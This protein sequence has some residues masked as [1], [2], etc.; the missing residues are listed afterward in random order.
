MFLH[1]VLEEEVYMK[2]APG[3]E[4]VHAPNLVCRLDRAI[5][6]LKQAPRAWYARLS[7]KLVDLGFKASKSDNSLYIVYI[8]E[9]I[10]YDVHAYLCG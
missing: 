4:N 5:Y 3:F 6:G 10:H 8:Q 9:K 7:S 1:G 2:Q